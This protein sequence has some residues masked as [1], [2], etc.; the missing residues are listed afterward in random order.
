L[1]IFVLPAAAAAAIDRPAMRLISSLY[2][3]VYL[4]MEE[5]P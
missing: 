4:D 2:T 1:S 5:Q 3:A